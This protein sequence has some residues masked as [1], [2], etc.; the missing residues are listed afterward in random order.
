MSRVQGRR[1]PDH[2]VSPEEF[3]RWNWILDSPHIFRQRLV[4]EESSTGEV[5]GWGA[6]YNHPWTYNRAKYAIEVAI[7][8]GSERRGLGRCVY[9]ELER[10]A[11]GRKAIALWATVRASDERSVRFFARCGFVERRRGWSSRL[12]LSSVIPSPP[13]P[14]GR[15]EGMGVIFTTIA[16][17]G[18]ERR[19]VRERL[20]RLHS[21]AGKDVQSLG[22]PTSPSFD[23]FLKETFGSPGFLPEGV[24]VA[25]VG[26][27]YVSMT[28][29]FKQPQEPDTLHV[30]FTGTLREFRGKGFAS[31]LKRRSV[32]FAK[33]RGYRYLTTD[34]DS[35]NA[36]M[37]AINERLGFK[38]ER[39]LIHGEKGLRA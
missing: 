1:Y 27:S 38:T 11:R 4:V 19:D 13:G 15:G 26:A 18:P 12:S 32:D 25:R 16:E 21:E 24:F 7:D 8:P 31:E 2:P 28:S 14:S 39:V 23:Q 33:A 22:Q 3:R 34:N 6:I 36:P 29:L 9:D 10:V 20:F 37:W 30:G 5:V 17:E 35:Q